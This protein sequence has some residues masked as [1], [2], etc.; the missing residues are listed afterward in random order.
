MY[1]ET[2][3]LDIAYSYNEAIEDLYKEWLII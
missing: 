1:K 2:K 3:K